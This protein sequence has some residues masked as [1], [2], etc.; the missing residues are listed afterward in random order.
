MNGTVKLFQFDNQSVNCTKS[1][2]ISSR[3]VRILVFCI[4]AFLIKISVVLCWRPTATLAQQFEWKGL[5]LRPLYFQ[6][7]LSTS[8]RVL[9]MNF[10]NSCSQLILFIHLLQ[11]IPQASLLI[12]LEDAVDAEATCKKT[13]ADH[14]QL[15]LRPWKHFFVSTFSS[16]FHQK[17]KLVWITYTARSCFFPFMAKINR[18]VIIWTSFNLTL[19]LHSALGLFSDFCQAARRRDLHEPSKQNR[20]DLLRIQR[21]LL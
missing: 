1:S 2:Y 18:L 12:L 11:F 15:R 9:F 20:A 7:E 5:H 19:I 4:S 13:D 6:N 8:M 3:S 21:G 16:G 17:S 14:T 10:P